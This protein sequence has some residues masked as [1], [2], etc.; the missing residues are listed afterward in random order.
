M[1]KKASYWRPITSGFMLAVVLVLF[2]CDPLPFDDGS[3]E[4]GE[5]ASAIFQVPGTTGAARA[6]GTGEQDDFIS[7]IALYGILAEQSGETKFN[8]TVA[9]EEFPFPI[10]M[11]VGAAKF[12]IEARD[13]EGT[14]LAAGSTS[15]NLKPGRNAVNVTLKKITNAEAGISITFEEDEE[16]KEEDEK[17]A[18]NSSEDMTDT[19]S[20]QGS[21][22]PF[23]RT[24][25][26]DAPGDYILDLSIIPD[27]RIFQVHL[28]GGSGSGGGAVS[29]GGNIWTLFKQETY[30]GAA[31]GSGA[32]S[33]AEF[34]VDE[35]S[36]L[37]RIHVG[38]PG[39]G[40]PWRN[41]S[42]YPAE[43]Y[44][45]DAGGTS[46]ATY[47]ATTVTAFGGGFGEGGKKNGG[48]KGGPGGAMAAQPVGVTRFDATAGNAGGDSTSDAP[49]Q[50]GSLGIAGRNI[51]GSDG[52]VNRGS[53][54]ASPGLVVV[55]IY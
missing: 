20:T 23:R 32:Y 8:Q 28:Y 30:P 4:P 35:E 27:V 45:G 14:V 9:I 34:T 26:Y 55:N 43:G 3:K 19:A 7:R 12:I 49:G 13:N 52:A 18:D 11:K 39:L 29:C 5:E 38:Q 33:F 41:T 1:K 25:I 16:N 48:A 42:T 44:D 22:I 53:E 24:I 54:P 36:K 51:K 47:Q 50:A 37:L 46:Y 15:T 21:L 31:G 10:S 2:G 17:T 40:A 6:V